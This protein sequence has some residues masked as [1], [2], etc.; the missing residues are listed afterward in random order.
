[1]DFHVGAGER[2]SC[3]GSD[4]SRRRNAAG[5]RRRTGVGGGHRKREGIKAVP[6]TGSDEGE[7][8]RRR[9]ATTAVRRR[10]GWHGAGA[11]GEAGGLGGSPGRFKG[12]RGGSRR[13]E[14]VGEGPTAADCS[15]GHCRPREGENSPG[16]RKSNSPGKELLHGSGNSFQATGGDE[17]A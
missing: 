1:V 14:S 12:T 4:G 10:D 8:A 16:Q 13:K 6:F 11:A 3:P 2:R 17:L 7:V 15:G 5:E 9:P